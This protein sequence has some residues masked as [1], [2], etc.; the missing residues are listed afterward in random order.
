VSGPAVAHGARLVV[1]DADGTLRWTTRAGQRCPHRPDE[2]RLMPNVRDTLRG[3]RWG[4]GGRALAVASNQNDVAEGLLSA[5]MARRLL[6][7]TLA[8]AIGCVPAG[9][10]IELCACALWSGCAC[11]KPAPGLLLRA[12]ARQH[13]TADETLFVGDLDTDR[14]AAR[15][16]GV[17]F[18]W[19]AAFFGRPSPP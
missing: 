13:A 5:G 18:A 3:M 11:R 6:E 9:T 14:E 2:W 15:R 4:P 8:E 16:A 19:A 1:F 12:M 17:R 7:A 10:A